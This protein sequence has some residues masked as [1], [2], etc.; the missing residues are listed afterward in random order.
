M[1]VRFPAPKTYRL[2]EDA[3]DEMELKVLT[4]SA[5]TE[6][7]PKDQLADFTTNT[8]LVT[9]SGDK[10]VRVDD[11]VGGPG[12]RFRRWARSRT[13]ICCTSPWPVRWT[14]RSFN[15]W[16]RP[17]SNRSTCTTRTATPSAESSPPEL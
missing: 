14:S 16:P 8:T 17:C 4:A 2:F 15:A 12:A 7:T 13:A 1:S 3:D 11:E 6:L 5:S 10:L 9:T